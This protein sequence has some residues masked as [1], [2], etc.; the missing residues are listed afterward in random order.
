[1]KGT[2]DHRLLRKKYF[3]ESK[4]LLSDTVRLKYNKKSHIP[5]DTRG[6][7]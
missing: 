1:M 2:L 4:H 5:W 7:T 3:T 6:E